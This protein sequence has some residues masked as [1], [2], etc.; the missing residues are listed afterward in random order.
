LECHPFQVWDMDEEIDD[1]SRIEF[2]LSV[3]T[4]SHPISAKW[5][6]GS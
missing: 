6:A 1:I 4:R 2:V 5:N 3:V